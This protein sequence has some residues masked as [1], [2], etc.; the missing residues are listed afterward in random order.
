VHH[1]SSSKHLALGVAPSMVCSSLPHPASGIGI[2][3]EA[4]CDV[5][6]VFV[7][8]DGVCASDLARRTA[9]AFILGNRKPTSTRT[10]SGRVSVDPSQT[11]TVSPD[12]LGMSSLR[13]D[14]LR[15]RMHR[16]FP[17]TATHAQARGV[18]IFTDTGHFPQG[19]PKNR[20]H[21]DTLPRSAGLQEVNL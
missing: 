9:T 17:S 6:A 4:G 3:D 20:G 14:P 11:K 1:I 21:E 18:R 19:S 8:E 7:P 12:V 16:R 2:D 15:P 10:D 13:V 5:E